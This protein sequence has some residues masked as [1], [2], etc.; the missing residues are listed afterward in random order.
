M[1]TADN[2]DGVSEYLFGPDSMMWKVNRESVL[3]LGGRAALLLQIAHP[4]VAAGVANHSGYRD[5]PLGRLRRTLDTM[6]TIIFGDRAQVERAYARVAAVHA[7]VRG[8]AEDGRSY[9]AHDPR[10]VK[11][12]YATLM[13][14]SVEVYEACVAKLGDDERHQLYLESLQFARMFGVPESDLSPSYEALRAWMR[15]MVRSG[16]VEVTPLARE[17]ADPILRPWSF[18]PRRVAEASALVTPALLPRAIRDGYGLRL[19]WHR[20]ALL[21]LGRGTSRRVLPLLPRPLRS[22]PLARV[23]V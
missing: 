22:L 7:R 4:L 23:G 2:E 8:E 10:L 17:L 18:I 6:T 21:A 19:G 1:L 9:S 13:Y 11:W 14:T 5:D 20:S 3:L 12:V 16:E 15:E